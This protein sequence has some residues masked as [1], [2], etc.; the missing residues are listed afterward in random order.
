[1]LS[2]NSYFGLGLESVRCLAITI[3]CVLPIVATSLSVDAQVIPAADGT[4]TRSQTTGN[5]FDIT[6]GQRNGGNLFHS[7]DKFSFTRDQIVNIQS[8]PA[9]RNIFTRIVGG[10][11]SVIDGI[12]KVSGGSSNLYLMNP[13]GI[14]FGPNVRLN[15]P[16]MF[17]ATT[18]TGLN[19]ENGSWSILGGSTSSTLI[20]DPTALLFALN[21][22]GS[23]A[24]LGNLSVLPGQSLNLIGGT[25]VNTGEIQAPGGQVTLASV[26]GS[27]LVRLQ[28]VG[29][30][31]SLEFK[32]LAA[33]GSVAWT[34]ATFSQLLAKGDPLH[35]ATQ[36]ETTPTG[37][38]R[39][40]GSGL[41]IGDR[42]GLTVLSGQVTGDSFQALGD[43]VIVNDLTVQIN[44][45]LVLAANQQ[46][47]FQKG[48]ANQMNFGTGG[49]IA[50]TIILNA[51]TEFRSD[52]PLQSQGRSIDIQS[53]IIQAQSIN[54]ASSSLANSGGTVTLHGLNDQSAQRINIDNIITPNQDVSIRADVATT[55]FI[56]TSASSTMASAITPIGLGGRVNIQSQGPLSVGGIITE[57]KDVNLMTRTDLRSGLLRV[58]PIFTFGGNVNVDANRLNTSLIWTTPQTNANAGNI[59]LTAQTELNAGRIEANAGGNVG[60]NVNS[61]TI[62][63]NVRLFNKMGDVTL[64][65]IQAIGSSGG[66]VS[67]SGDRVQIT[68]VSVKQN[69]TTGLFTSSSIRAGESLTINHRGGKTNQP[70]I[71]GNPTF[72][73][74]A[75]SL[76]VGNDP[77]SNPPITVGQFAIQDKNVTAT[78]G[79]NITITTENQRPFFP[80]LANAK[81]LSLS[82][83]PGQSIQFSLADLGLGQPIDPN[84]DFVNI[85]I[86]V[87]NSDGSAGRLFDST[88]RKVSSDRPVKIT[89]LLTYIAPKNRS[90]GVSFE[91][92]A[93]DIPPGATV[94]DE[95]PSLPLRFD[96]P[97]IPDIEPAA[98]KPDKIAV[99]LPEDSP[100]SNVSAAEVAAMDKGLT[101]EFTTAG[102]DTAGAKIGVDGSDLTRQIDLKTGVKAALIYIRLVAAK[103][104]E[105]DSK[106]DS[107]P[108]PSTNLKEVELTLVTA[109]GRFRKRLPIDGEKL[110][111]TARIFRQE[112][113][114][115]L[116]THTKTYLPASQQLYKWLIEPIRSD[117]RSQGI[118]NLVFVPETGLKAI[119]YSALHDG[120]QFLIEQYSIGLMPSLGLTQTTY[121]DLRG[122]DLLAL[123]ISQPTQG[124]TP[125][126]MV[127][128]EMSAIG[129]LWPRQVSYGNA[130]ATLD[131]L[132]TGRQ[133][134]PFRIVHLATHANFTTGS[135]QDSY[136]QLWDDRLK[137]N[138]IKQLNWND[139]P[140]E[141]LVL[142]AC[143]TA[144]G[145]RT[146]ELGLAGLAVQTGVKT[147]I[148]SLWS[149]D[150]T[151][152]MLL[153]SQ[154]YSALRTSP[155]KAAAL[156][157]AQIK[158]L[159]RQIVVNDGKILGLPQN[160]RLTLPDGVRVSDPDFQHPYYWA[161][162]TLV[163]NPW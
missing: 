122:S 56:I 162:F 49:T 128:T 143:R 70:F 74:S 38:V 116:R 96:L 66:R 54:T 15:L 42:P 154:F 131:V 82:V 73:G 48:I 88:G 160:L 90:I 81:R 77:A 51:G 21:Q 71:I 145:D 156:R 105:I 17:T 69:I 68:G 107:K 112:V 153:F 99:S 2:V 57:G 132:R 92:V 141:L 135:V 65:S 129:Q 34:P 121:Q 39:L 85:Y 103:V 40:K 33:T 36:L 12:L 125:L 79:P 124:Q 14:L 53:P 27:Q 142:S 43:R 134:T 16:G 158:L 78:P 136:I 64:D 126:P 123:G 44:G 22:P 157:Q 117:L 161:A 8:N 30:I 32:P 23:V 25:V 55:Q 113:V 1:M 119:P 60:G 52:L 59:T 29:N 35:H 63:G 84:Q 95:Y 148:A 75:G 7:F 137:L 115:P 111:A 152:T 144:L 61:A 13:A 31:L 67:I 159:R 3:G 80:G 46:L 147:T 6:G 28:Q 104:N 41:V 10:E 19:F 26:P 76:I 102:F 108:A 114:N 20:G 130:Q 94:F 101:D 18:A 138:Q 11:A 50:G 93:L 9:I 139:P 4:N 133:R 120:K 24:N 89:D 109:K 100:L 83:K 47:W 62:A 98:T 163:G 58:G 97:E 155:V 149:V 91:I 72:N 86:R 127:G 45:P 140:V 106:A 118:T 87:R 110:L 150:D 151:A 146:S 5:Q 37:Q